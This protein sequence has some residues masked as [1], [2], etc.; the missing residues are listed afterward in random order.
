M[1]LV[2]EEQPV[3]SSSRVTLDDL[4]TAVSSTPTWT[5]A[6]EV[7]TPT[8]GAKHVSSPRSHDSKG[9]RKEVSDEGSAQGD[10]GS[11]TEDED[12]HGQCTFNSNLCFE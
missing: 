1:S 5:G 2:D 8:G 9:K 7:E 3:A 11:E 12:D 10:D 4:P 6:A